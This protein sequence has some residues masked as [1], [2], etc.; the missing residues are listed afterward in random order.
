MPQGFA[1]P[2][3]RWIAAAIV[4]VAAAWLCYAGTI[5]G[6]A[7]FYGASSNAADWVLAARIEPANP[8]NWYRLGR[9]RQLDF[10]HTDIPLAISY[11]RRAVAL[12]PRSPF[13][14]LDLASALEMVGD[15]AEADKYYRGAQTDFPISAEVSWKYGNFLL[16]QQ[17]LPEAYA[18]IHHAVIEEPKLMPL[19]IS[20]AWHSDPDVQVL[21]DQVLPDTISADWEALKYLA[22]AQQPSAALTV[23]QKLLA[24]R[25]SIDSK[26]LF[27]FTD[28]LVKQGQF[29]EAG[30]VWRQAMNIEGR[31]PSAQNGISLVFDGGFEG[32]LSNGGFGWQ[33]TDVLG[34]DFEFD[35][36]VK[37]SGER[38][39]RITFDGSANLTYIYPFQNVLVTPGTHYRFSGYLRT[40]QISTD[41]GVQFEIFDPQDTKQ[42]NVYTP[43]ETGTLPWTLE[44]ADFTPGP[45]THMVQIRLL[46]QPSQRFD[47]KISGTAWVDDVSLV[48]VGPAQ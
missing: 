35:T 6:L 8:E 3:R 1:N 44:Q 47:N 10:D 28:L 39:A 23:W 30:T 38:S 5:R 15:N 34:A 25:P 37:H 42:L 45:Q 21:L 31:L 46:R 7:G 2:S 13:Y 32:G 19:A 33:Q 27:A 36:V 43:N 18:E 29:D 11:Y 48:A 17:R 12:N 26:T 9:Y 20:R 41:R 14:K 40:D 4:V 22:G 24:K 16:R